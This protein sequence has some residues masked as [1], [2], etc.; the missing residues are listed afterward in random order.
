MGQALGLSDHNVQLTDFNIPILKCAPRAMM[1][2]SFKRCDW[3][4]LKDVLD[5]V[6]WQVMAVYDDVDDKWD[7]FKTIL[8]DA[9]D[10]FAPLRE[11]FSKKSKR[12]TP[13]FSDILSEK[14]KLKNK[15]KRKFDRS[16]DSGDKLIFQK[17]KND[18]KATVR[19]AK[20]DY[21]QSIMLQSKSSFKRTADLWSRVNNIIGRL[22]EHKSVVC[23]S[24][25]LDSLNDYFQTVAVGPTHQGFIIPQDSLAPN[26]YS[27]NTVSVSLVRS[28]LLSLDITKST[29]PGNLSARFLR[30]IANQIVAPLTDIF[31]CS[32]SSGQVPSEWKRSHITPIYKGGSPDDPSN[33]RPISV[34]PII[35]K[36]LEKIV[37]DQLSIY[38]EDNHLL[39]PHQGAYHS[40]KSTQ[41]ILLVA[42]DSIV[43]L[44]DKDEAVC[45]AFLD[46]RKA[47]D[48][49]DHCILLQ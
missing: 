15:A 24:L 48:S 9:L 27:F 2:R 16:G 4:G 10:A 26:P 38:L 47:F 35:A 25:S 18:L 44:L 14:I 23:D 43:H 41:D 1:V 29:G 22:K 46:L 30:A 3:E 36:I 33:F 45:A 42:V 11:V 6:P 32:L 8:L 40:G 34:V 13:W 39:H 12:P 20:I 31:N 49:L 19:Q 28:H 5:S 21:L 37:S 7:F 17:L